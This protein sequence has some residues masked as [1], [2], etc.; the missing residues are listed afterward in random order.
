M[1]LQ[2]LNSESK[3]FETEAVKIGSETERLNNVSLEVRNIQRRQSKNQTV[4]LLY[5]FNNNER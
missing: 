5:T 2:Q 4:C 1:T 3:T